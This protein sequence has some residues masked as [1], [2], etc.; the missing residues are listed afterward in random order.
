MKLP[1]QA[2]L[3]FSGKIFDVYQW[4]QVMY[5]G[6]TATFEM[7]KRPDTVQVIPTIGNKIFLSYEEQPTYAL[8]YSFLG[9]RCELKEEPLTTAKRELLEESGFESSD[10]ELF[11]SF[12]PSHKIDWQIHY[13]LA[14]NCQKTHVAQ[15]DAGE[16]LTVKEFSFEQFINKVT[17]PNFG[18]NHFSCELLQIRNNPEALQRL[19]QRL[20][21]KIIV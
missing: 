11:G 17:E 2:N 3:V 1:P 19:K 8:Q 21:D 18:M 7:L 10:W 16:K 6:T 5:D 12:E 9:G 14:R 13:F 15:L 4:E 20:Y